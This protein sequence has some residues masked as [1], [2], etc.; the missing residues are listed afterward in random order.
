MVLQY[1]AGDLRE[2]Q[3]LAAG[4][5]LAGID[6]DEYQSQSEQGRVSGNLFA[7]KGKLYISLSE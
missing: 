1:A 7:V 2:A 6:W 4:D 3:A 5:G